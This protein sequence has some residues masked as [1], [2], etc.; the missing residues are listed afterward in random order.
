MAEMTNGDKIGL[1]NLWKAGFVRLG[2]MRGGGRHHGKPT[3]IC[4]SAQY[5]TLQKGKAEHSSTGVRQN[6]VSMFQ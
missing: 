1:R 2:M 6:I 5:N 3:A 4:S